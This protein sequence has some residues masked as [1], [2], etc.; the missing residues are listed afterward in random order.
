MP[1]VAVQRLNPF[2]DEDVDGVL[3]LRAPGMKKA[4]ELRK[5]VSAK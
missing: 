1:L 5:R 2:V 3:E 4:D